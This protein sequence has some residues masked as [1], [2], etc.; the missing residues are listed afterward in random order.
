MHVMGPGL[1]IGIGL[2]LIVLCFLSGQIKARS[3]ALF[4][5]SGAEGAAV[6]H[7]PLDNESP[8]F[9]SFTLGY[10]RLAADCYWLAFIAYVGD[11]KA[12]QLDK[13]RLAD[14]YLDIVTRL[15]PHF[16]DA[17]WFCAF[18]VGADQGRPDLAQKIIDRGINA[19][20]FNWSLPFIAGFNQYLYAGN[21][22]MAARYY[23]MAARFPD[24]P[25]WLAEQAALLERGI[26]R[27]YKQ[28]GVWEKIYNAEGSP[29]VKEK[30]RGTLI[31]LWLSVYKG[32]P[33][34]QT[35]QRAAQALRNLGT[36]T[37]KI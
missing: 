34:G 14:R 33:D 15:D 13:Y 7:A 19:N 21:E 35:R 3:D 12:R 16:L 6:A 29:L 11:G 23:R 31:G 27:I 36:S 2:T 32:A 37:L 5:L 25:P 17:Y 10:D 18:A 9:P 1:C 4:S 28:I 8:R 20:P 24:A 26:P 30:A 22:S